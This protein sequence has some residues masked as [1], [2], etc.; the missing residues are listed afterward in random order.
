MLLTRDAT[1]CATARRARA[2]VVDDDTAMRAL[3]RDRSID[4][5]SR[6]EVKSTRHHQ[7]HRH[8]GMNE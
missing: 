1:S 4:G 2:G 8:L 6:R 7:H 5:V 3:V